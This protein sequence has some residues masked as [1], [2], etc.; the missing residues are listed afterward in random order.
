[1]NKAYGNL[2][3]ITSYIGA[4][5]REEKISWYGI[6]SASIEEAETFAKN[7]NKAIEEA[8]KRIIS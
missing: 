2:V 7:L 1:M 3:S 6:A 5:G 4:K 8:K